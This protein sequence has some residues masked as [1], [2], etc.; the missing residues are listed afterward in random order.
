MVVEHLFEYHLRHAQKL[1]PTTDK[2]ASARAILTPCSSCCPRLRRRSKPPNPPRQS[3]SIQGCSIRRW[4]GNPYLQLRRSVAR[5]PL[6]SLVQS[7]ESYAR[8]IASR[9]IKRRLITR[10]CRRQSPRSSIPSKFPSS[11]TVVHRPIRR[12]GNL[13]LISR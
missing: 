5:H 8:S 2:S 9:A 4:I 10:R 1:S 13:P 7:T 11:S 3:L 6:Q 12:S